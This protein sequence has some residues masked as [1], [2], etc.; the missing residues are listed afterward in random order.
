MDTTQKTYLISLVVL[1]V[2]L[3]LAAGIYMYTGNLI[4]AIFFAPPIIHWILERRN[5]LR[6]R[7]D[8]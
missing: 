5:K 7:D 4:I 1:L 6:Q 3:A 2:C 8:G